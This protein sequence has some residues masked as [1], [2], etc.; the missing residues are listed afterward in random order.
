MRTNAAEV[1][2]IMDDEF[3][4]TD[5]KINAF[6]LSA[7]TFL[8]EVF[9]ANPISVALAKE[10]ERWLSAHLITASINRQA[11]KEG[12]G[13]ASIEYIGEFGK[14]LEQTAYGQMV[15]SMDVTGMIATYNYQQ[16]KQSASIG[17][18]KE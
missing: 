4:A 14:G 15:I 17:A 10:L 2:E 12:A 16:G 9:S 3:V 11:K 1:R 13:G 18:I 7:S 8:D 5:A 6:I